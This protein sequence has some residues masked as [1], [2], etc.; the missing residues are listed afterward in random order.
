MRGISP[1]ASAASSHSVGCNSTPSAVDGVAD[2]GDH[3]GAAV[4]RHGSRSG[5]VAGRLGRL[6]GVRSAWSRDDEI[7]GAGKPQL[8]QGDGLGKL[9]HKSAELGEFPGDR[10]GR[11]ACLLGGVVGDLAALALERDGAAAEFGDLPGEI[12]GAA[13]EVGD[14]A[15]DVGAVTQPAGDGVI[16]RHSGQRRDPDDH[17]FGGAEPDEQIERD[18]D[19]CGDQR[20]TEHD[21]YGT[22]PQHGGSTSC[23]RITRGSAV[24]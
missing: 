11:G 23:V 20:H 21:E 10:F 12:A 2:R 18:A 24:G 17:R 1:P 15:T 6:T 22:K 8:V 16:D 9:F 4:G 3:F 14:L 7:L 13:G 19:R 5:A